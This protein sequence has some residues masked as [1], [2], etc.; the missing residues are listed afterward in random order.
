VQDFRKLKVWEKAHAVTLAVYRQ[1]AR[2]PPD[3]RFGL[4]IQMRRTASLVPR[5]I[6]DG[7]GRATDAEFWKCL[8]GAMGAGNQLE[9]QLLLAHDLGFLPKDDYQHLSADATEVKRMLAGLMNT[10][11][12]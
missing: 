4:T 6:A 1:T 3:E 9:Y 8:S 12:G 7:C 11:S 5:N 10:L 2:F